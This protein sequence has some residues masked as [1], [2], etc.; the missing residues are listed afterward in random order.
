MTV[1]HS[2]NNCKFKI[3]LMKKVLYFVAAVL[4]LSSCSTSM[5]LSGKSALPLN[6]SVSV[7][8]IPSKI[9]IDKSK[10][11]SATSETTVYFG[12][13]KTSDSNF[14]DVQMPGLKEYSIKSAAVFNALDGTGMDI[15]VNPKYVYSIEKTPFMK[16]TTCKVSGYGAKIEIQ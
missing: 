6:V 10:V 9:F 7:P 3:K 15:I 2:K 1:L 4:M 13:F 16:K 11:L 12:I 14:L 5:H 8:D